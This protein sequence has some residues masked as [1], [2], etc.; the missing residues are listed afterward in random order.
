MISAQLLPPPS[1]GGS[2]A[3]MNTSSLHCSKQLR[4]N[5]TCGLRP[6]HRGQHR[7]SLT[8]RYCDQCD[9]PMHASSVAARDSEAGVAFCF[10]CVV[11]ER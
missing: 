8:L 7:G 3:P 11:V 2:V 5:D 10:M 1:C 4:S 6:G 9:R